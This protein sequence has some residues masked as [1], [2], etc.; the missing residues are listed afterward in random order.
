MSAFVQLIL[1][2]P[3]SVY[4]QDFSEGVLY[5]DGFPT[6]LERS[7]SRPYSKVP[8][9]QIVAID[10]GEQFVHDL[11]H[12]ANNGDGTAILHARRTNDAK[13]TTDFALLT[14]A[15]DNKA[16]ILHFIPFVFT[17]DNDLHTV[18]FAQLRGQRRQKA[19]LFQNFHDLTYTL[20]ALFFWSHT[21]VFRLLQNV[22][23][24]FPVEDIAKHVTMLLQDMEN[25]TG[26]Q[27]LDQCKVVPLQQCVD[28]SCAF[29]LENPVQVSSNGTEF[30]LLDGSL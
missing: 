25:G 21:A 10:F 16:D 28:F 8:C 19:V 7:H 1:D 2:P 24:T 3:Y 23:E 20:A 14:V 15:C 6:A 18:R 12:V 11:G 5:P 4:P 13:Q 17:T 27:M 26:N 30:V 9:L 22:A 29:I